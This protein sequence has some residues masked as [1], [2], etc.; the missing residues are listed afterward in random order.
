MA[1]SVLLSGASSQLGVFLLPRLQAA[2]LGVYALSRRAPASPLEVA[3]GV[4]WT[5]PGMLQVPGGGS[6]P[7]VKS[8]SIL[9]LIS[10]GPLDLALELIRGHASV[11]RAVV[12]ST[13]SVLSKSGSGHRR[14]RE[15]MLEIAEGE[16]RLGE[17]C[18]ERGIALLLLRPTL[19][20]GCG[21]DRNIS[22]LARFGKRF[23]FIPLAAEAG[24]LRQPAHADDLAALAV[25][26]L[27]TDRAIELV[28]AACG[29]T[30][31]SY[32]QMVERIAAACGGTARVATFPRWLMSAAVRSLMLL[33]SWRSLNPE[34]V[35]RQNRD[36]VF[37]DS[38]LKEALGYQP[39]PFEPTA[40]DFEIPEHARKL[41]LPI[42]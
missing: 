18:E 29:G 23:G 27:T 38:T 14:E 13:S 35:M 11:Q 20:Y 36:L 4:V 22:L 2:G 41:Q 42:D 32:R 31:L 33:P 3:E 16:S 7:G 9:H 39:R 37:D 30:T 25:R 28:S 34:M 12:F 15:Q 24:G 19:I 17:L 26:A 8:E 1:T 5:H 40:A 6:A 21:L 10:C